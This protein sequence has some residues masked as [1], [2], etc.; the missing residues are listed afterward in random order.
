MKLEKIR[1]NFGN[2]VYVIS[3]ILGTELIGVNAFRMVTLRVLL[4]PAN[5]YPRKTYGHSV[6]LLVRGIYD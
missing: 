1:P 3:V 2:I 5:P 4:P 6:F